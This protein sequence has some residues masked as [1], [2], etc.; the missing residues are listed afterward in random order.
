MFGRNTSQARTSVLQIGACPDLS[1]W[2]C[3]AALSLLKR[4]R[5]A[6][7]NGQTVLY[8]AVQ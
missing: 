6:R 4:R 8:V 2:V 1:T 5:A 3:T 7:T